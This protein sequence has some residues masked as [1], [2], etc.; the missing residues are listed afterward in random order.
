MATCDFTPVPCPKECKQNDVI[1]RIMRKD[2]EEHLKEQCLNRDYE[3][4]YCGKKDTYINITD[5]HDRKCEE[6][7][8][9]CP[10]AECTETIKRLNL[11]SHLEKDC[12]YT[13]ISCKYEGIGCDVKMKRKDKGS[14]EQDDKAHLHQAF[15]T[16]VKLQRDLQYTAAKLTSATETIKSLQEK[17]DNM[18]DKR[19]PFIF[20]LPDYGIKKFFGTEFKSP[21]FYTS[22]DGYNMYIDVCPN[23]SGDSI[24][25]HVSVFVHILNGRNDKNLTWPF[26]GTVEIELLNQLADQNHHLKKL[27]FTKETDMN[28]GKGWGF[29]GFIAHD[30]LHT[31]DAQ[32]LKDDTLYFRI[33]AEVAE[34]KHWMEHLKKQAH[35]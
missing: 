17:Y 25:T 2:L 34:C 8:I 30:E 33:S 27:I 23:G 6:K 4:E 3:C 15:N 26:I 18:V 16:V 13:V 12:Q 31:S 5:V 9:P 22:S 1:Q 14:H 19:K 21:S 20:E 24:G 7:V 28:V 10:N 35:S 29:L 32:Y 11:K